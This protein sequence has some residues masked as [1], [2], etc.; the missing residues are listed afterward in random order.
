MATM[1]FLQNSETTTKQTTSILVPETFTHAIA[2]GETGCGKTSSFI[3]PNLKERMKLKHGILLYDYKGKEHLAVKY[4]AMEHGRLG[5]V[6]EIG[7]AWGED[8]NFIQK[9]DEDELDKFFDIILKHG[10]D[11]KYWQNSAKSL[12]QLLLSILGAIENVAIALERVDRVKREKFEKCKLSEG[13]YPT[14]RTLQTLLYTC[15][16]FEALKHFINDLGMLRGR[17]EELISKAARFAIA[18]EGQ[19]SELKAKLTVLI[20]TKEALITLIDESKNQFKG[21]GSDS[22]EN[23]TQNIIGTLIAP[24]MSL[25]RNEHFNTNAFDIVKALNAGKIVVINVEALSNATVES[26]NNSILYELSKRTRSSHIRPISIFIDEVQRVMSASTDIPIDVFREA[27]V[28]LFLATQN[29]SL[30]K[31]KLKEEKFNALMGNLTRKYYY[32]SSHDEA[33]ETQLSLS[34][35]ETFEFIS[36]CD[37]YMYRCSSKPIFLDRDKLLRVEFKYQ[38][39]KKVLERFL[40]KYRNAKIIIDFD[41]RLYKDNKVIAIDLDT[42]K[43]YVLDSLTKENIEHLEKKVEALF[44]NM[45][46]IMRKKK[47]A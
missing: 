14:K 45:P 26:L 8:I 20:S 36:S 33:L 15:N 25:A 41:A 27:K 12:G 46:T 6:V 43:E 23:L 9:M 39:S 1:G 21:F 7:K 4:L 16:T 44:K 19:S 35:L 3:Y 31:E 30:L 42:K 32:K 5:D 17:I 38:K 37:D 13:Y 22:N 34:E 11:N 24:L 18:N 29:S 2:F 28:D 47:A 10:D 40:Y